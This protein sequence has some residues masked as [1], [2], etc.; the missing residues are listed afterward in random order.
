MLKIQPSIILGN[1]EFVSNNEKESSF[2]RKWQKAIFILF[3]PFILIA[4]HFTKIK[5]SILSSRC[6]FFHTLT[7]I[8]QGRFNSLK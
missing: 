6:I 4:Y 8:V 7:H 1:E 2:K 5:F 3:F